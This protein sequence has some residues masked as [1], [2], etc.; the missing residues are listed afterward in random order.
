MFSYRFGTV[1]DFHWGFTAV[2]SY[3][4]PHTNRETLV[5]LLTAVIL[6]VQC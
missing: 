3:S 4:K 1:N 5:I 6:L 2:F